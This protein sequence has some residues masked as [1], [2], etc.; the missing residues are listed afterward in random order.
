[1]FAE[2]ADTDAV[3]L[4]ELVRTRQV[5]AEELLETAIARLEQ[6]NPRINAVITKLY[7]R[8]RAQAKRELGDGP[9]AGVPFLFKD[10]L[11][12]L[13]GEPMQSG[14]RMYR[15]YRPDYNSEMVNRYLATGAIVF[16]KT[17]TPELGLLPTTEPEAFGP[18][19]NPWNTRCTTGGS[20]GGSAAAVAARVV[21]MASGGD[22][23]GS[24]RI[25]SSACGL[26]GMKPTRGRTP[27][28]PAMG[29]NWH[30]FAIEHVLTRSVRDSA[31]MLDAVAGP[32][33][34]DVHYLG[35]SD[36]SFADEA[37]HEPRPLRIAYTTA[38]ILPSDHVHPDC[39]AAVHDAVA[40]LRELGHD[41]VQDEPQVDGVA[42][43]RAFLVVISCHTAFEIRASEEK[44]GRKA[45]PEDFE[46]RTWLTARMGVGM[47]IL[48]AP[49]TAALVAVVID[50][51]HS[52]P[53]AYI[54]GTLGCCWGQTS[55][56]CPRSANWAR[57]W[58]P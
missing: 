40:L 8:A 54:C 58:P 51:Q 33:A 47:P 12:A 29:E 28:G 30:G 21:P 48:V 27:V 42:F 26:L 49:V 44:M 7:D 43:A 16:G 56:T 24:I 32:L 20:S 57:R 3:G 2:Y 39:V 4:A 19:R 36:V 52:A 41:V 10:L 35:K 45:K 6:Y 1:M 14:S 34:G 15:G 25:P 9:F 50:P 31:T 46:Q 17:N 23:G 11:C 38:P 53:L 37:G 18:S 55:S 13:E 22:G 5:S